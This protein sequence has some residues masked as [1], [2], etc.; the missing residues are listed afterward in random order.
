MHNH[1]LATASKTDR[2]G[3]G[4]MPLMQHGR[5]YVLHE[6]VG[7][8]RADAAPRDPRRPLLFLGHLPLGQPLFGDLYTVHPS[9]VRSAWRDAL[10]EMRVDK[11]LQFRRNGVRS[12]GVVRSSSTRQARTPGVWRIS[13]VRFHCFAGRTGR[14]IHSCRQRR[15]SIWVQPWDHGRSGQTY[16]YSIW[17]PS[18]NGAERR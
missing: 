18:P 3:F 2:S 13:L 12:T 5:S 17:I 11:I 7:I 10:H 15:C 16:S 8:V 4:T 6:T 9:P 1:S 14:G